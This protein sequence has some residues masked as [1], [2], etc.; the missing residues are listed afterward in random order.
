MANNPNQSVLSYTENNR[1]KNS[2]QESYNRTNFLRQTRL[3][4]LTAGAEPTAQSVTAARF[5]SSQRLKV[6]PY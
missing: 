5:L 3:G 6:V 4:D 2:R 1:Q